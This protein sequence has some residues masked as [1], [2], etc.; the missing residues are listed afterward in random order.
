MVSPA[1]L[2]AAATTGD[3]GALVADLDPA[4]RDLVN[5][6]ADSARTLYGDTTLG[7][8]EPAWEH[9][10]GLTGNLA[11]LRADAATR[12]AGLLFAVPNHLHDA[13]ERVT[14]EFGT[15]V[16]TL[17]MG[18]STVN[19]LRV[20]TRSL[21]T[22]PPARA[23]RDPER[24]TQ[25]ETLRKMLLAMVEDIRV[26]LIRLASRTQTLRYLAKA[27][28]PQREALARE[29]LDIY[30]PL[31]NRL[32]VWQLKWELEDLSFR[33]LEPATYS[34]IAKALDERR[35]SRETFI[36]EATA[37]LAAALAAARLKAEV[38]G[39]PK[40]I[41]SI[42]NK[43]LQKQL[44]FEQINDIR[45]LRVLVPT[46]EDCYTALGVVHDLWQPIAAEFDDYIARPK[47]NGYRSLHTAVTGPDGRPLEVQI[48]TPEMH[49]AAE[50]GVA[51]HWRY[52]EGSRGPAEADERIA[53]LREMLAWR[54]EVVAG[55]DWQ[56]AS[57]QAA[58]DDTVYVL[59]PQGR[60]VDLPRG[61]TPID[62]AY[63]LH[64]DLG[65]R[66]RGARVDGAMVPLDFQLQNGQR[67][68]ITTA[69]EGGP[70][71]D[72]LTQPG[73]LASNRARSKVRQFF[74][75]EE[76]ARTI[77]AGRATVEREI[78]REGAGQVSLD[79]LAR[80]LGYADTDEFFAAVGRE[81]VSGKMLQQALRGTG[82]EQTDAPPIVTRKSQT[83]G[84]AAG[85]LFV[86]VDRL[87]TQL[88]GCCKPMPPDPITGFVTR[89]KG[90]SVH[91]RDCRSL[92]QLL[93]RHPER[94]IEAEWGAR[95]TGVY[96]ADIHVEAHDRRGLLRD[97]S[98]VL[99]RERINVTAVNTQSRQHVAQMAFTAEVRGLDQLNRALQLI[100]EVR[101]VITARRR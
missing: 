14:R 68:E 99:S 44:A 76:R 2:P 34:R 24:R 98:D 58:R 64:T 17:V 3:I 81:D 36:A 61:A 72:W 40:H 88:A 94:A 75:A 35:M 31:A 9:A 55:S 87:M 54:D 8:G 29:T 19:K 84:A 74:V 66:C 53:W 96:A 91:R 67:V 10:L 28:S 46:I 43:M 82:P 69:K 7:T 47:P 15:A 33:I 100:R 23:G 62:F 71:R 18:I 22:D 30:A 63:A 60:V 86:G 16:A 59:T 70:S 27:G 6:A 95:V 48:R 89:G 37:T 50:L 1:T 83:D 93:T 56:E 49:Q 79:E 42:H 51:A 78:Q 57:K 97:V 65:H 52:K 101:G 11:L 5:R 90:I 32:G 73:F 26:V 85:V 20:V 80:D 45:G 77:A 39:R 4:D 92:A 41:Y 21:A 25:A 38:T 13:R 12:A